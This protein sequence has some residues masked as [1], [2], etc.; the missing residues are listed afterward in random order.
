MTKNRKRKI[1]DLEKVRE[2]KR[3]I[4]ELLLDNPEIGDYTH[5]AARSRQ[6]VKELMG[7]FV[8]PRRQL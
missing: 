7:R 2:A 4:E 5:I 3:V 6:F 8:T 1:P